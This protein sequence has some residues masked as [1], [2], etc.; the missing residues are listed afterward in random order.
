MESDKKT[1][2]PRNSAQEARGRGEG[3]HTELTESKKEELL[4]EAFKGDKDMLSLMKTIESMSKKHDKLIEF[5]ENV[6]YKLTIEDMYPGKDINESIEKAKCE[7]QLE[8]GDE[9][10]NLIKKARENN[11]KFEFEEGPKSFISTKNIPITIGNKHIK[12]KTNHLMN[13]I[14]RDLPE[15]S[16]PGNYEPYIGLI[17]LFIRLLDCIYIKQE[18]RIE[19]IDGKEV[20]YVVDLAYNYKT[21]QIQEF[22]GSPDLEFTTL[23]FYAL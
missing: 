16:N 1:S 12:I 17:R 13:D 18:N 11:L 8:I 22:T 14:M 15:G 4:L 3:N 5:L 21:K 19:V 9:N 20:S 23:S 6:C 2:I 7:A 10:L